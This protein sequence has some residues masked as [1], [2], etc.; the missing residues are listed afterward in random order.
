MSE[1]DN[2]RQPQARRAGLDPL[3]H[4]AGLTAFLALLWLA[5]SGIYTPLLLTLGAA[6]VAAC[7]Y[8]SW[9][10]DVIDH[11]G[12]PFHLTAHVAAYVPWLAREVVL[13]NI[14]VA[15]RVIDP[16]LPIS[17]VLFE[18]EAG[19]SHDIGQVIYANSITLTP[20]TV[21]VDLSAGKIQVHALSKEAAADLREG[22]MNR[23]CIQVEGGGNG[24]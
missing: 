15:R 9:R 20:G 3:L 17:P 24:D 23:R 18:V 12:V 1:D 2:L 11:E 19:Q 8:L 5:L 21:S 13:A 16:K 22:E 10:M 4:I 14:D 7:V 6:S